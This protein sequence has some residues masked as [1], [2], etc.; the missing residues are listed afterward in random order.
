MKTAIVASKTECLRELVMNRQHRTLTCGDTA[1]K[2][3]YLLLVAVQKS[4]RTTVKLMEV[5]ARLGGFAE[6][7]I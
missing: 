1:L 6:L 3:I 5:A 7:E 4:N 2:R